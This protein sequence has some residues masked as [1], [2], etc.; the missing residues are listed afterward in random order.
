MG[1][2]YLS[3]P[4][5][6]T[7]AG[8]GLSALWRA[9]I[10]AD[11]MFSRVKAI[12]GKEFVVGAV[13]ESVLPKVEDAEGS[14]SSKIERMI[15][16][17][18]GQIERGIQDAVARYGPERV[19]V[20]CG[21]CDNGAEA[22][23]EA[24]KYFAQHGVFPA[25][26]TLEKQGA[27]E[28][29]SY[30]AKKEAIKGAALSFAT[31]CSSSAT[32]IMRGA[33]LLLSG[34]ADAVVAGGV[35]RVSD[36]ALLGFDSLEAVSPDRSNPFSMN[37]QGITLGEGA[38]FFLLT[39]ERQISSDGV[40]LIGMGESTDAHHITAPD[41]TG[42]Y[43]ALAMMKALEDAGVEACDVDYVNLHGTGTKQNDAMES[44]AME[45]VFDQETVKCSSTKSVTGHT[46][47]AAGAVEAAV[48]Y[49]VL[50]MNSAGNAVLP[51]QAWDGKADSALPRL[52]IVNKGET[53]IR[54]PRVCMTNTFA[55]GGANASMILAKDYN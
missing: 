12:S 29:A 54:V 5:I 30:I 55:F 19:A 50:T 40:M 8:A 7:C 14:R 10:N 32:A 17:A 15:Q 4:G 25:R 49:G 1:P 13:E 44:R 27:A 23:L 38:A 46:L 52:N 34:E 45:K 42:E 39:R 2:I 31:A 18:L 24:H 11:S 36:I 26:Y 53:H 43:A 51:A 3:R 21:S 9:V 20:C 35:D 6:V 47:G 16:A 33:E 48:C 22:S 41:E 37:R 28:G